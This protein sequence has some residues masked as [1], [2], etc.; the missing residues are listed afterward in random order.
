MRVRIVAA[1]KRKR[2]TITLIPDQT[3][4]NYDANVGALSQKQTA[5]IN[6]EKRL[7]A[8]GYSPKYNWHGV[9][10]RINS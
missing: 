9:F 2:D 1:Q 6:E 7:A 10:S 5:A 8:E 3:L 4:R